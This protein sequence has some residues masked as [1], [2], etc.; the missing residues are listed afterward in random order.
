MEAT[1][2]I[3]WTQNGGHW[4]YV[5]FTRT[6]LKFGHGFA[7]SSPYL[8]YAVEFSVLSGD[9]SKK[10]K[11]ESSNGHFPSKIASNFTWNKLLIY[12]IMNKDKRNNWILM[13]FPTIRT[14]LKIHLFQNVIANSTDF[15]SKNSVPAILIGLSSSFI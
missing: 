14:E 5:I 3:Q 4:G 8:S 6:T 9:W 7:S 15:F 11:I 10:I 12:M 1:K 2:V 13:H